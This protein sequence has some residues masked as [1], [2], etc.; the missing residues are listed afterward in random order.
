MIETLGEFALGIMW[1]ILTVVIFVA[2]LKNTRT[3]SLNGPA[4]FLQSWLSSLIFSGI[5]AGII[6]GLGAS[7]IMWVFNF[8][9][10]HW[11]VFAGIA[12]V[13]VGL[14]CYGAKDT[15]SEENK[16]IENQNEENEK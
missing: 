1:L 11:K 12:V 16:S 2:I 14:I 9:V 15:D 7:I 5:I 8:I 10:A 4:G 6:V 3:I 13:V